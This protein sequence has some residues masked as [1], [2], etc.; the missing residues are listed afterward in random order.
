MPRDVRV[1]LGDMVEA[2]EKIGVY[3]YQFDVAGLDDPRTF[4]AVVRNLEV[5]GEAARGFPEAERQQMPEVDWRKL[6]GF[7]DVLIHQYFGVDR[8][9]VAD[10]VAHKLF[11]LLEVLR[12]R[13]KS[14][15]P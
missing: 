15:K 11:P 13:L 3:T 1:L 12:M 6:S 14:F 8:D 5:L 7:R 4:D 10:V 9:I 2:I